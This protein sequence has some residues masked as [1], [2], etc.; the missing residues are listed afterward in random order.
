MRYI[1]IKGVKKSNV[2]RVDIITQFLLALSQKGTKVIAH[3]LS[4]WTVGIVSSANILAQGI[5]VIPMKKPSD[6][7]LAYCLRSYE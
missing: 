1:K 2:T 6:V 3:G 4:T 5:R 7:D